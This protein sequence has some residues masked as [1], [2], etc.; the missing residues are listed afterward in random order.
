[1]FVSIH[2]RARRV[3][4]RSPGILTDPA[5][6]RIKF[7]PNPRGGQGLAGKAA[8]LEPLICVKG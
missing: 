2:T 1:M 8:R 5:D 3:T 7:L 4:K 6:R